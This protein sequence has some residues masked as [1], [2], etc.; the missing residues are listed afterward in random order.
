MDDPTVAPALVLCRL[1]FL[2]KHDDPG[3][4]AR[5]MERR[6]RAD[7]AGADYDDIGAQL[8]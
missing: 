3:T 8:R 7:R 4:E 2:L 5:E 1:T 6:A